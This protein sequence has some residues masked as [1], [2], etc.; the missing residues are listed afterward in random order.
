MINPR[1]A[2]ECRIFVGVTDWGRD[3]IDYTVGR[4]TE[5]SFACWLNVSPS[6]IKCNE[7][8]VSLDV[9]SWIR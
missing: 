8:C 5:R 4:M 9:G 2:R 6:S 7:M 1:Q 3:Y